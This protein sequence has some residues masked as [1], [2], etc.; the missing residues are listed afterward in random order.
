MFEKGNLSNYAFLQGIQSF[1]FEYPQT[2]DVVSSNNSLNSIKYINMSDSFKDLTLLPLNNNEVNLQW[3]FEILQNL[4]NDLANDFFKYLC[5]EQNKRLNNL[6]HSF[7]PEEKV[8]T[9]LRR[10]DVTSLGKN[11]F[12]DYI[13]EI[14]KKMKAEIIFSDHKIDNVCYNYL[15]I[16]TINGE[17]M[18]VDDNNYA[19]HYSESKICSGII[20]DEVLKGNIFDYN[21]DDKLFYEMFVNWVMK[22]LHLYDKRIKIGWWNFSLLKF[23]DIII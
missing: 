20:T 16:K 12:G 15:P 10:K 2:I 9:Y 11:D 3:G 4:T 17:I 19:H 23:K 21:E 6:I 7:T 18:F 1:L 8:R 14:C 13:V 22:K 5:N